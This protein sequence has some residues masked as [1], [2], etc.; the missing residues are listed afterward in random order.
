MLSGSV[1]DPNGAPVVLPVPGGSTTIQHADLKVDFG[2]AGR[3]DWTAQVAAQGFTNGGIAARDVS[4]SGAA[5]P[6]TSPTPRSDVSPS[7]STAP[8]RAL[9]ARTPT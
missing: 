1:A 5:S 2:G 3:E 4:I 7:T 9:P 6:Q 8:S